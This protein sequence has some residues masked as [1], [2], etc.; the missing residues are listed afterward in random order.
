MHGIALVAAVN[1]LAVQI[2]RRRR[3]ASTWSAI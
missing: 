2:V 1:A 3:N